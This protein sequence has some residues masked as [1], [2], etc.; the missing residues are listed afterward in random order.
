MA[1]PRQGTAQTLL[2]A[3]AT[4]QMMSLVRSDFET[5]LLQARRDGWSLR[6]LSAHLSMSYSSIK[7]YA[8]AAEDRGQ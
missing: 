1:G 8:R 7:R 4:Q 6:A 2:A 3:R 5:A